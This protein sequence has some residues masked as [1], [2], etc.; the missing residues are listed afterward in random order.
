MQLQEVG[1]RAETGGH[2][3]VEAARAGRHH[4]GIGGH[5]QHLA[6]Q[7]RGHLDQHD[8]GGFQRLEEA[9]GKAHGGA[10]ADP[11]LRA[12]A[13]AELQ[14]PCGELFPAGPA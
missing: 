12:I 8:A 10:I 14:A 3:P 1:D 7:M 4:G 6:Q 9:G 11:L 2:Q 13:G 5:G